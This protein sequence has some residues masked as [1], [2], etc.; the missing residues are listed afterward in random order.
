MYQEIL[1][2]VEVNLYEKFVNVSSS[3]A[4]LSEFYDNSRFFSFSGR[5]AI[6]FDFKVIET[7]SRNDNDQ[8]LRMTRLGI[9][10]LYFFGSLTRFLIRVQS[11]VRSRGSKP[12][13]SM[14]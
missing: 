13:S 10:D 14:R 1:Y 8:L 12:E 11:S 3:I 7:K 9:T 6:S 4:G 2:Q 5:D